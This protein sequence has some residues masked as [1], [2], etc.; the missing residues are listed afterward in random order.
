MLSQTNS[1]TIDM[2]KWKGKNDQISSVHITLY[3][4]LSLGLIAS[5]VGVS[6]AMGTKLG[7]F[8]QIS[9]TSTVS[10]LSAATLVTVKVNEEKKVAAKLE[11]VFVESKNWQIKRQLVRIFSID[12]G[13]DVPRKFREQIQIIYD[14][15]LSSLISDDSKFSETQ[16]DSIKIF[17]DSLGISDED[18]AQVHNSIGQKIDRIRAESGSRKEAAE[19]TRNLHKLIYMTAQ[20]F[21]ERKSYFLLDWKRHLNITNAQIFVAK[22][23]FATKILKTMLTS[24]V[25]ES[26]P[27]EKLFLAIRQKGERILLTSELAA[28]IL[29]DTLCASIE[30]KILHASGLER[31]PKMPAKLISSYMLQ[32]ALDA[33]RRISVLSNVKQLYFNAENF[34]SDRNSKYRGGETKKESLKFSLNNINY[35][36]AT[37]I[38]DENVGRISPYLQGHSEN[39]TNIFLETKHSIYRKEIHTLLMTGKLD[40][41]S[42]RASLLNNLCYHLNFPTKAA[43]A[44]HV[45][46]LKERFEQLIVKQKLNVSGI[47]RLKEIKSHLCI[48]EHEFRAVERD[49]SGQIFAKFV[50]QT[51]RDALTTLKLNSEK[52]IVEKKIDL[53]LDDDIAEDIFGLEARKVLMEFTN[54]NSH[55]SVKK[56][57]NMVLF[58]S[59]VLRPQSKLLSHHAKANL[60]KTTYKRNQKSI[61]RTSH[62]HLTKK[63]CY[64]LTSDINFE[65]RR[66][67]YKT[68]LWYCLVTVASDPNPGSVMKDRKRELIYLNELKFILGLAPSDVAT[69]NGET[70]K[71]VFRSQA[72]SISSNGVIN[73]RQKQIID[74]VQSS[75]GIG[76]QIARDVIEEVQF[77]NLKQNFSQRMANSEISL[78]DLIQMSTRGIQIAAC[79]TERDKLS[80]LEKKLALSLCIK[81][82]ENHETMNF[83]KE[84]FLVTYP[85]FLQLQSREVIK[86]LENVAKKK[87]TTTFVEV[88]SAFKQKR[89]PELSSS[90]WEIVFC[91]HAYT[92]STF[93]NRMRDTA[94]IYSLFL[95]WCL[96]NRRLTTGFLPH[97]VAQTL[98]LTNSEAELIE[99]NVGRMLSVSRNLFK[100]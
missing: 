45:N 73:T 62:Q 11:E 78:T 39:Q 47:N 82:I 54:R 71:F 3:V 18:A 77:Q 38:F 29:S 67:I 24:S 13:I 90:L 23:D 97:E 43:L 9:G 98:S 92:I 37:V 58:S 86:L 100:V 33:V 76:D 5:C 36:R 55:D 14:K 35:G 52:Q 89:G 96:N 99:R 46:I 1:N 88:V 32:W 8:G 83:E 30:A 50:R 40:A 21:G 61:K 68:F 69:I 91:N 66:G 93:T 17:K 6:Y 20:I 26:L 53:C 74:N 2:T 42:S 64:N 60:I 72:K 4:T 44:V 63:V 80:V 49:V 85:D 22:R 25:Y 95:N 94:K 81:T 19:T 79:F 75:L 65:D 10:A 27:D 41:A 56:F 87:R 70:L 12:V 7:L 57:K 84:L 16:I 59:N 15:Y 31:T 34:H 48:K 51:F 28:K